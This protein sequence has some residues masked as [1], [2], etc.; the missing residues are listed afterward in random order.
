MKRVRHAVDSD[1]LLRRLNLLCRCGRDM[2]KRELLLG[3]AISSIDPE[4]E[5]LWKPEAAEGIEKASWSSEIVMEDPVPW[6]DLD[7][8]RARLRDEKGSGSR[9]V[10]E[11][12]SLDIS[13]SSS[14]EASKTIPPESSGSSASL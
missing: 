10:V 4:K 11:M 1:F 5:R 3:R 12:N 6:E 13:G 7:P 2:E 9:D 8:C 14:S